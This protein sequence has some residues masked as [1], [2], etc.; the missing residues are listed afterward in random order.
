MNQI[1]LLVELQHLDTRSDENAALRAQLETTL[2]DSNPLQSARSAYET[3][4]KQSSD[5][6]ARLRS[7][8][9]ETSG[10]TSKLKEVNDR[11]Y[12]GRITNAKELAGLNNDEKMLQ[13]RKSEL[14]DQELA[15]MEQIESAENT[16]RAKHAAFEKISA[17][18]RAR[19][20]KERAALQGLDAKDTEL[21]K[22][23]AV[24]RAQLPLEFLR[25]YDELRRTKKGRAVVVMKASSCTACGTAIPSG[26]LSRLRTGN[27]LVFCTSCGRIIAP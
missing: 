26:F 4:D 18:T 6:K 1:T 14:E 23:R 11:L 8:E 22:T 2:A 16:T 9:L 19:N 17:E 20:D 27:E 24:L 13:R 7:L 12:S 3:Q 21:E 10:L 25:A 5:L 15:L